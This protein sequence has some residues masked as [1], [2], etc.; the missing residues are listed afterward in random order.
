MAGLEVTGFLYGR[1]D[2]LFKKAAVNGSRI[3]PNA[4]YSYM[5]SEEKEVMDS[6]LYRNLL[7]RRS[8]PRRSY[9]AAC[10]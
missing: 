9:R 8:C 7:R 4:I 10:V 5:R 1:Y 3:R 6:S 2:A